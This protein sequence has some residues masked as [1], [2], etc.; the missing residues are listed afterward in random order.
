MSS[1]HHSGSDGLSTFRIVGR[2]DLGAEIR[3]GHSYGNV[4]DGPVPSGSGGYRATAVPQLPGVYLAQQR[5]PVADDGAVHH[6]FWNPFSCSSMS[7]TSGGLPMRSGIA[8]A[9]ISTAKKVQ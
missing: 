6:R 1:P 3:L 2:D 4:Q 9:I 7:G 8:Q 5:A